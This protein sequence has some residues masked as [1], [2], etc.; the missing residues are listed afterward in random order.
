ML[1]HEVEYRGEPATVTMVLGTWS[2]SPVHATRSTV[3]AQTMGLLV[4][5]RRKDGERVLHV[6]LDDEGI[7][8][9]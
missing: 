7:V 9:E 8:Q 3:Y 4:N 6:R 5:L 2:P 1:G